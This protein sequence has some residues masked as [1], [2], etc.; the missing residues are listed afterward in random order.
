MW[1]VL[2]DP[3]QK[4]RQQQYLIS[5]SFNKH[6]LIRHREGVVAACTG[7]ADNKRKKA[8]CVSLQS[9]PMELTVCINYCCLFY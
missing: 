2:G 7:V 9:P 3:T 1:K 6:L 4:E 8:R 5:Q